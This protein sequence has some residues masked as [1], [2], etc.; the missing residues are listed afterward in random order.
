MVHTVALTVRERQCLAGV[1]AGAGWRE[2]AAD[3]GISPH[4]VR[5]H[6]DRAR[7]K[8]GCATLPQAT[9]ALAR[10]ELAEG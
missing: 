2:I 7:D 3:L 6:L 8:L 5:H 10:L 4:T 1:A 9:A